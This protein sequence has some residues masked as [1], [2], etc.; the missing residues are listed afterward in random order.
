MYTYTVLA[1]RFCYGLKCTRQTAAAHQPAVK[2]SNATSSDPLHWLLVLDETQASIIT[3]LSSSVS[4][5]AWGDKASFKH[6]GSTQVLRRASTAA[7]GVYAT[8]PDLPSAVQG[9]ASS[10]CL[11][12]PLARCVGSELACKGASVP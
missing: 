10:L 12:L 9:L 4:A 2:T 7:N 3:A 6:S 8:A 1:R 5:S 11:H